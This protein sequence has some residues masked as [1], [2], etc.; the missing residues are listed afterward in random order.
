VQR[1]CSTG[2]PRVSPI[3][4]AILA[5]RCAPA[6]ERDRAYDLLITSGG[7]QA[8][9][10]LA[11]VLL[12]PG[13]PVICE[14]PTYPVRSRADGARQTHPRAVDATHRPAALAEALERCGARGAS[15]QAD[16]P[17]PHVPEPERRVALARAAA[18]V[19]ELA[20]RHDVLVIED[21]PYSHCA[22][23]ATRCH[24]A[25]AWIRRS[26]DL[27][28]TLSKVLS[29]G[30][31]IGYVAA[32]HAILAKLTSASRP[33]TCAARTL[34]QRLACVFSTIRGSTR[35]STRSE[36]LSCAPR[37]PGGCLASE[38][39]PGRASRT[40]EGGLFLWRRL[41]AGSTRTTCSCAPSRGQVAFVPGGAP[42]FSTGRA[43][44]RC[45]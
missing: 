17:H 36:I 38:L 9:D 15:G 45:G 20:V 33:P 43:L 41:R 26:R 30:L 24:A 10:L 1:R 32:D 14:G 39:P 40:P 2:R 31:R 37:R 4:A 23:R 6:A 35:C 11:R 21:D 25:Q 29:P 8:L 5:D 13:D 19:L 34:S 44:A 22:S 42:P 28:R 27:R 16:L 7:Q 3:C 12:D 18:A